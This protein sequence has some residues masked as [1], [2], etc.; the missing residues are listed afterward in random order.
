MQYTFNV[1][2]DTLNGAVDVDSLTQ[3]I[4][5]LLG[6]NFTQAGNYIE[7]VGNDLF[8]F[9]NGAIPLSSVTPIVNAHTGV[10]LS[11]VLTSPAFIFDAYL[12][13]NVT[14]GTTPTPLPLSI[15]RF[16]PDAT[17]FSHTPGSA[18]VTIN[19]DEWYLFTY[20]TA[21]RNTAGNALTLSR[22]FLQLNMGSGFSVVAGT[23]LYAGHQ[24]TTTGFQSVTGVAIL[25]IRAGYQVRVV[26]QRVT[27]TATLGF[28]AGACSLTIQRAL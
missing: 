24:G 5:T 17:V 19:R 14:V 11:P 21:I 2:T 10:S 7:V 18:D 27:G 23:D 12:I 3:E 6:V 22:T 26:S 9:L 1:L 25:P 13:A 20:E 15:Q 8:I 4:T 16:V 28:V